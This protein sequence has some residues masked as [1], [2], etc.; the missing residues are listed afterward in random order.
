VERRTVRNLIIFTIA[1]AF[2]STGALAQ[3]AQQTFDQNM[4]NANEV[5]QRLQQ[6]RDRQQMRDTSHDNRLMINKD[7]SIGVDPAKGQINLRT[8][9]GQ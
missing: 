5:S 6:E 8:T 9:R 7:T 1:V 4:R 3:T 2:T